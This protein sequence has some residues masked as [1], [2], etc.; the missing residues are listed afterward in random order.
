[1]QKTPEEIVSTSIQAA[2]AE[3]ITAAMDACDRIAARVRYVESSEAGRIVAMAEV[4]RDTLFDLL[5]A[6]SSFGDCL[7]ARRAITE[8]L[9]R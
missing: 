1:M 7:E 8:W 2:D 4:A 3:A 5:N 9:A 6:V